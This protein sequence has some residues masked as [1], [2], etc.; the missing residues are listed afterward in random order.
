MA[1]GTGETSIDEYDR[2]RRRAMWAMPSGLYLLGSCAGDESNLMTINWVTQ[3]ASEPKL[4]AVG[5][6]R[7]AVSHRLVS[8]GGA[9]TVCILRRSDRAVVR[10]FVRPAQADAETGA[11]NGFEVFTARTGAPVFAGSAAWLD[12]E[13]RH[14]L[15]LGSHT[16]FV[17]EVVDCAAPPEGDTQVLRME[18]T[19][20]NYGG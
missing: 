12:C 4:V 3:V 2:R 19:K 18:D 10:K 7:D 20:M 6:E 1:D 14:R 5:V 11:L 13:V 17:G 16:L 8:A 15:D 9:F